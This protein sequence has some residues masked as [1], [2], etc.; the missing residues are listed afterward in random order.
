MQSPG[1]TSTHCGV[2]KW[3]THSVHLLGLM[4]FIS[5]PCEMASLG[6]SGKQTSQLMHSSVIIIDMSFSGSYQFLLIFSLN[7]CATNGWTKG[8]T[9]PP[10][11]AISRIMLAEMNMY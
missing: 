1:H 5:S 8:V 6:H 4:M 11:C 9:S 3:P 10:N 2:S 7:R